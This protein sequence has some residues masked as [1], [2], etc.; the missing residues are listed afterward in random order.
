MQA[1]SA[2][3][4]KPSAR[5]RRYRIE[6]K[7]QGAIARRIVYQWFLF[8]AVAAMAL[9]LFNV[10]MRGDFSR[11]LAQTLSDTLTDFGILAVTFLCLL[12]YFMLDTYKLTNRFAG[13]IY[14][15]RNAIRAIVRGE[16]VP[17]VKFRKGDFWHDLADDFNAMLEKSPELA[18]PSNTDEP[19]SAKSESVHHTAGISA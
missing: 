19:A 1:N 11:P 13:P 8:L 5:R 14:R 3:A 15:L 12:P 10:M 18:A 4:K 2:Q 9:P 16:K 6:R 7:V 17:P